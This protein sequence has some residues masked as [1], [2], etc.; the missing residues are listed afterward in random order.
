[1]R[2]QTQPEGRASNSG[3]TGSGPSRAGK[4][5]AKMRHSSHN[6]LRPWSLWTPPH[7]KHDPSGAFGGIA[8]GPHLTCVEWMSLLVVHAHLWVA[9]LGRGNPETPTSAALASV[10]RPHRPQGERSSVDV[11]TSRGSWFWE[12]VSL[13]MRPELVCGTFSKPDGSYENKAEHP[14]RG[15]PVF[16][17]P[18]NV[19][20]IIRKEA[21][22]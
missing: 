5:F 10:A 19:L 3:S 18:E 21:F 13:G 1:M 11:S 6:Q 22:L 7:P 12:C 9:H 15:F 2:A 16:H 14:G 8:L 17:Y 20:S 4:N